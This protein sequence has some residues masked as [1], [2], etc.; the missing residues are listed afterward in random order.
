MRHF[1][2][3]HPPPPPP[4]H[5]DA[6]CEKS[7]ARLKQ[8]PKVTRHCFRLMRA[9]D[10]LTQCLLLSEVLVKTSSSVGVLDGLTPEEW[11]AARGSPKRI[12]QP[13]SSPL[14]APVSRANFGMDGSTL[15]NYHVEK[16]PF[17]AYPFPACSSI[18]P[19]PTHPC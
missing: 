7:Q 4:S 17:G 5:V 9:V 2:L 10:R 3:Y 8:A 19:S 12:F 14:R 18:S 6:M 13:L 15:L 11:K 16:N 1:Y